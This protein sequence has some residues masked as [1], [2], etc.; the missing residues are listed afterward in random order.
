MECGIH[1]NLYQNLPMGLGHT[2][3][4][5]VPGCLCWCGAQRDLGGSGWQT[6]AGMQ[7][8]SI[9][10]LCSLPACDRAGGAD[11]ERAA[12]PAFPCPRAPPPQ[13]GRQRGSSPL[14]PLLKVPLSPKPRG[15]SGPCSSASGG[16]LGAT[17]VSELSPQAGEPGRQ[18]RGGRAVWVPW[19]DICGEGS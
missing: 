6:G 7:R 10:V 19:Q 11:T 1:Q 2:R 8:V 9:A 15:P 5:G 18:R 17:Q 3:V 14:L 13:A 16:L 4:M 12:H